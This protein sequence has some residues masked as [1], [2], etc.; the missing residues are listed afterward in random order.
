M[1]ENNQIVIEETPAVAEVAPVTEQTLVDAGLSLAEQKMA[2]DQGMIADPAKADTKTESKAADVKTEVKPEIP[3]E[4]LDS[5]E[6]IHDLYQANPEAFYKLPKAT[7]NLYHNSKGLYKRAKEEEEKRKDIEGKS[8]FNKIQDSVSRV[9]LDRVKARLANPEGLTIEELQELIGIEQ[10]IEDDKPLTRKDLEAIEGEKVTKAQAEK[11]EYEARQA[12]VNYKVAKAEAYAKANLEDVTGGK[13]TNIDDV[14]ALAQEL[15]ASKPRH[16]KAIND[17]FS[18]DN[19]TEADVIEVIVDIAR[20]NPKWGSSAK[21]EKND[22]NVEKMVKNA[23]KQNTSAALNGG[24]GSRIVTPDELTI[25]DAAKL[26]Q[27]QW[28][29]LPKQ[30]RERLLA[31]A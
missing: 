24:K 20:L 31:S 19:M 14:V 10:K 27:A 1:S 22:G 16:A 17:A 5:F 21:A 29:K 8:E 7:R 18:D 4:E 6:K 30:T 28:M 25:E 9:K 2:K 11:A 12:R 15:A 23:A 13:Y 26:S 3:V